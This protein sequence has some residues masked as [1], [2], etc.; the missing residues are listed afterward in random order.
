M[1]AY[2]FYF[3]SKKEKEK[4]KRRQAN[5]SGMP[6]RLELNIGFPCFTNRWQELLLTCLFFSSVYIIYD[7]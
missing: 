1:V 7:I 3:F 6:P 2:S 4:E 5:K